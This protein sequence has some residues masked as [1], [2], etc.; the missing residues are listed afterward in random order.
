[1]LCSALKFCCGSSGKLS[2]NRHET[3]YVS[4]RGEWSRTGFCLAPS[5]KLFITLCTSVL[6]IVP[7]EIQQVV[8]F[9]IDKHSARSTA[10]REALVFGCGLWLLVRLLSTVKPNAPENVTLRVE[11][12]EHTRY[13]HMSWKHPQNADTK[14]GWVTVKYQ[15]RV[16]EE[17]NN[18]WKVSL[19]WFFHAADNFYF[20]VFS[21]WYTFNEFTNS[22]DLVKVLQLPLPFCDKRLHTNWQLTICFWLCR[23]TC[24]EHK[25]TSACTASVLRWYTWSRCAV[26]LIMAPGVSGAT[27]PM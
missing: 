4:F 15:I 25:R 19:K 22:S 18:Q 8:G 9:V 6:Q 5:F 12:R 17:N 3:I 24:L 26:D 14:S 2:S 23:S 1:M 27:A 10:S 20:T 16:K 11:E 7:T 13:L 21:S